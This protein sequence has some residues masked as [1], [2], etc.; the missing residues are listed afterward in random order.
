MLACGNLRASFV[1]ICFGCVR[2]H[3]ENL[4]LVVTRGGTM[5]FEPLVIP[6]EQRN[7]PEGWRTNSR[8]LGIRGEELAVKRLR[9]WGWRIL[10]RN[11]QSGYGEIDIIAFDPTADAS[12]VSLVEVK[13]RLAGTADE[14]MPELAV[15]ERRRERYS[16]AARIFLQANDWARAVR[17][18]VI[19]I[20]VTDDG[21]AHLHLVKG[22]FEVDQ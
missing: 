16:N 1:L 21:V 4:Y 5:S 17:F 13:T 2:A 3:D 9:D 15:D 18:D 8:E 11:W 14:Q 20:T 10:G 22:A 19:A 12:V 7:E 6:S